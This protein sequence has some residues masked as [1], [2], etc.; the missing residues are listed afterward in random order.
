MFGV[1]NK[2]FKSRGLTCFYSTDKGDRFDIADETDLLNNIDKLDGFEFDQ[3][4]SRFVPSIYSA[5]EVVSLA[6]KMHEKFY[7]TANN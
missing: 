6:I 7:G 5:E 4:F 3:I 1:G 2:E